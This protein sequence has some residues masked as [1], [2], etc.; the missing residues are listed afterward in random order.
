M[1]K[2]DIKTAKGKRTAGSY[3]KTR[4]RKK[5]TPAAKPKKVT[6]AVAEKK[7]PAKKT[8]AAKPAAEKKTATAAEKKTAE[9]KPAA[10]KPAA[11]KT[12]SSEE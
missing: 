8:A 10:K 11:K 7:A 6:T 1:G 12:A 3:G 2:G 5:A 4:K 9:K